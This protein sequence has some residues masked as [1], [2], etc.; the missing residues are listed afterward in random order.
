MAERG[1]AGES[2]SVTLDIGIRD[3][4][5]AW[6]HGYDAGPGTVS[7]EEE[8]PAGPIEQSNQAR[9]LPGPRREWSRERIYV[10][11]LL[12]GPGHHGPGSDLRISDMIAGLDLTPE[13]R[14]LELGTGLG[15]VAR[16]IAR[17]T[18]AWVDSLE[19]DKALATAARKLAAGAAGGEKIV[20]GGVLFD[21]S[22]SKCV[23]HDAV[24]SL[25]SL[26]RFSEPARWL[27]DARERMTST[28]KLLLTDFAV[29]DG[30]DKAKLDG[31]V[32]LSPAPPNLWTLAELRTMVE[33]AGFLVED[34]ADESE[35]CVRGILQELQAFSSRLR[36][37]PLPEH[38]REWV[39]V[40]VEYWARLA[41]MIEH[42]RLQLQR[43]TAAV[44]PAR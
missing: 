38:W 4:I 12:F 31:W 5:K 25:E 2:P 6:W 16:T 3:R 32:E 27:T 28:G 37:Q 33:Q 11:Q 42:G 21:D 9:V 8:I 15:L 44:D 14:T 26:H 41:A 40:E 17:E 13:M 29:C 39:M 20:I 30:V 10:V 36:E 7:L 34:I 1:G 19:P 24:V 35:F 43:M 18:G 22:D 23:P